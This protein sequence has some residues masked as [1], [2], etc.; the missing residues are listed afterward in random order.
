MRE[1]ITWSND[2]QDVL[3]QMVSLGIHDSKSV[4]NLGC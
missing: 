4:G 2:S 1:A 3:C